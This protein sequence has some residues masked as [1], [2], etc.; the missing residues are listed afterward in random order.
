MMQLSTRLLEERGLR[1]PWKAPRSPREKKAARALL[2]LSA[3]EILL[4]D[5]HSHHTPRHLIEDSKPR[6]ELP[7]LRWLL[8]L[9]EG[10]LHEDSTAH[11]S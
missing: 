10:G 2:I 9:R 7:I 3:I 11:F 1:R 6:Y 8:T 5:E 4:E